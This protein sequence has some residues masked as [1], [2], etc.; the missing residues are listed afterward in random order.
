[1][2]YQ[3]PL[4]TTGDTPADG[5]AVNGVTALPSVRLDRHGERL[6]LD[7]LK[8]AADPADATN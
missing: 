4:H 2:F 7:P 1:M 8:P 6:V 3:R 5:V